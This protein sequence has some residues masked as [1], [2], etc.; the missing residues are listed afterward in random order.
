M[1]LRER[2]RFRCIGETFAAG[3]EERPLP[4]EVVER[5]PEVRVRGE[6]GGEM[7][8]LGGGRLERV[9]GRVSADVDSLM[10]ELLID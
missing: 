9:T 5:L 8:R 10:S 4:A 2:C 3:P 7:E 6:L 1:S